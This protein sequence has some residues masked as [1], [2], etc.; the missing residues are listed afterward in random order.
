[1]PYAL[2]VEVLF[3][4][5]NEVFVQDLS[6]SGHYP[7]LTAALCLISLLYRV[8]IGPIYLPGRGEWSR[9]GILWRRLF[10]LAIIPGLSCQS[11]KLHFTL[12]RPTGISP[13]T[14]ASLADDI[15][16]IPL[17]PF[18]NLQRSSNQLQGDTR[19]PVIVRRLYTAAGCLGRS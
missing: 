2:V 5:S 14:W 16:H 10:S 6:L 3:L 13:K 19:R 9:S 7:S 18:A 12:Q 11:S 8:A 15:L 1:M 17:L 4:G